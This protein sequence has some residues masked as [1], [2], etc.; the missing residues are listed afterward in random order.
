MLLVGTWTSVKEQIAWLYA[1]R[2][3]PAGF[4]VLTMDYR[5]FGQSEGTPRH[6][7]SPAKKVEDIR[8]ASTCCRRMPLSI[9]S[10]SR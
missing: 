4:A 10:T 2:L 1:Q 9:R 7:E 5:G 8:A 3:A 6:H